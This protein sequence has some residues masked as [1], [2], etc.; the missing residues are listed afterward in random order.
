MTKAQSWIMT[1]VA[2]VA[3]VIGVLL[4]SGALTSAQSDT[5]TP[6]PA[7]STPSPS[8]STGTFKSNE[9][10]AHEAQESAEREAQE[11]S[12]QR[13]TGG[14][15]KSNEDPAHEAQESAEREAQED[16]GQAPTVNPSPTAGA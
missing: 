13:P 16:S 9:D 2:A 11:D 12:G 4:A 15:F 6:T 5:P 7:A 1:G 10:P 3:L 14:S 8:G